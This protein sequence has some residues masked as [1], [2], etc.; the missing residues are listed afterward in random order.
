[1]Y[2]N[3]YNSKKINKNKALQQFCKNVNN[4][5]DEKK[6][7]SILSPKKKKEKLGVYFL[8]DEDW[9]RLC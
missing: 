2:K 8:L 7:K 6:R 3:F 1:M 9:R 4:Q 5:A